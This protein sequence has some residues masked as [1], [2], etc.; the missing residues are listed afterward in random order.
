MFTKEKLIAKI[1]IIKPLIA[2]QKNEVNDMKISKDP[3][4]K[5]AFKKAHKF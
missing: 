1:Q 3:N 4:H 2:P 5:D